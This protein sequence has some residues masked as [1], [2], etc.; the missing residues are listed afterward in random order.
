[1]L[2]IK[3]TLTFVLAA[4]LVVPLMNSCNTQ[5][6]TTK[7]DTVTTPEL[8]AEP[9]NTTNDR[10]CE[11]YGGNEKK[12]KAA[13]SL[14]R[15]D[16]KLT[17]YKGAL[18]NWRWVF[19]NAPGLREQTFK[20][21]DVMYKKMM[22]DTENPTLKAAYF[23]TLM[24]ILDQRAICWGKSAFLTGKKA[25]AYHKNYPEKEELIADYIEKAVING[26]NDTPASQL[27]LYWRTLMKKRKASLINNEELME[28]Y[29]LIKSI[30]DY[31]ISIG[32]KPSK[33]QK[34][35]DEMQPQFDTFIEIITAPKVV[36]CPSA[37][38]YYSEKYKEQPNDLKTVREYYIA[39]GK[40]K[41]FKEDVFFEILKRYTELDP[42]PNAARLK[43][44][45]NYYRKN[46]DFVKAKEHY[47]RAFETE[48]D[49][50]KKAK[51]L[52]TTANMMGYEQPKRDFAGARKLALQAA[53]LHP[54]WGEP[55]ILIGRMYAASGKLCGPGT[56]FES[57][58][59]L[60]P[61]M[62]MWKKA[63]RIDPASAD[64]AQKYINEYAQYMPTRKDLFKRNIPEGSPYSIGCWIGGTS[65]ARI[66]P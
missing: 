38:E 35:L 29:E 62:D 42:N 5:K 56:G 25:L 65:I 66:K 12:A 30:A 28:A 16:F 49:N 43:T 58:K 18:K 22:E 24:L 23:D 48:T 4:L 37:I 14:Y 26:G 51:I 63:R 41:C 53:K 6:K 40:F 64:L 1:M 19:E 2:S 33:Y 46:K 11:M 20:D 39:L 8:P 13:I 32:N 59:I 47:D 7:T 57:Q 36:D 15:D 3:K 17:N 31:N 10:G 54:T 55:Y 9:V 45:G 50:I 21:G 60:W 34:V 61:A 44:M 27:T 52:I